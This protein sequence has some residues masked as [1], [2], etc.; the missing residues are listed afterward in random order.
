MSPGLAAG[1]GQRP[2]RR[3][4][5]AGTVLHRRHPLSRTAAVT[6]GVLGAG[7]LAVPGRAVLPEVDMEALIKAAQIDPRRAVVANTVGSATDTDGGWHSFPGGHYIT[8]VGY[9]DDGRTVRIAG[10]ANVAT[11]SYGMTTI[12]LANWMATHG[13]SA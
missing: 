1:F 7:L 4:R 5:P 12:D 9:K 3:D 6:L 10:S 8:V 13:Y 11:A 2:D